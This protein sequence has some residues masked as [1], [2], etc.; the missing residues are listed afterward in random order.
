MPATSEHVGVLNVHYQ[1]INVLTAGAQ[2][3]LM[4][5]TS[6]EHDP[7]RGHGLVGVNDS[8]CSRA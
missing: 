4:D 8:I 5:Y 2:A 6:G 7:S 3:F 1:P